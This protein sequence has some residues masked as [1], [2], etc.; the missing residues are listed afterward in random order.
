MTMGIC[1]AF[2]AVALIAGIAGANYGYTRG[3]QETNARWTAHLSDKEEEIVRLQKELKEIN[4]RW[5]IYLSY[6]DKEIIWLQK[7]RKETRA[8]MRIL[9]ERK[10]SDGKK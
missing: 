7:E 2:I 4:A 8:A 10:E 5:T 1:I 9:S 6:K 3:E